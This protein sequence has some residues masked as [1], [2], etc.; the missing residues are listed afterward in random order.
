MLFLLTAWPSQKIDLSFAN[1]CVKETIFVWLTFLLSNHFQLI[2]N[3]LN[4]NFKRLRLRYWRLLFS[5]M[6]RLYFLLLYWVE[7]ALVRIGFCIK[8]KLHFTPTALSSNGQFHFRQFLTKTLQFLAKLFTA[9]SL[10]SYGIWFQ[11]RRHPLHHFPKS[12]FY[13]LNSF[14]NFKIRLSR[15]FPSLANMPFTST[16]LSFPFMIG[17]QSKR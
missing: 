13:N 5:T 9:A 8:R 3:L 17:L 7:I 16:S 15:I 12:H 10:V 14:L 6:V 1:H 11:M 4:L 2:N